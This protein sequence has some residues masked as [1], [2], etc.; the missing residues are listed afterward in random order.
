MNNTCTRNFIKFLLELT[1]KKNP[2]AISVLAESDQKKNGPVKHDSKSRPENTCTSRDKSSFAGNTLA[3]EFLF[4]Y[5]KFLS[6]FFF[7]KFVNRLNSVP[8]SQNIITL[9]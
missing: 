8:C 3:T 7:C 6:G 1:T 5:L 9:L 4:S 2:H